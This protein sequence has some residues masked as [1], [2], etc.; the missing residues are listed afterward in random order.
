MAAEP[1]VVQCPNCGK[2]NRVPP[3][4]T[5]APHCGNCGAT[6]P[7]LTETG[8]ADFA[9]VVEKSS[10]PVLIDFWAPWCGP[11]RM[12]SPALEQIANERAGRLKLVKVNTDDA[13]NLSQRFG[14]R[15]IPTLVLMAHGKEVGRSVGAQPAPALRTWVDG[16]LAQAPG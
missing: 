16:Q 10:L 3:A 11:C 14:I 7:W 5:G 1:N 2:G 6:L 12:V 13:P 15:G 9:T 4:A 8:E